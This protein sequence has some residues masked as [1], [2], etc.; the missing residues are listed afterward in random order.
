M[1]HQLLNL[2]RPLFVLDVETTGLDVQTAR[3]VEIGFQEW[4]AEGMIR[5][6]RSLVN[7]GVPIPEAATAVHRITDAMMKSCQVC[8]GTRIEHPVESFPSGQVGT[9][10]EF[11]IVPTFKQLASSL[12]SGFRDCDFAGKNVRI[13]LRLLT[14]EI[15]RAGQI[16]S[17]AGARIVD[18]DRLEQLAVPRDLGA[19]H[20]KYVGRKHDG[21]HGALAD[22]RA[23][24]TV[25]AKQLEAHAALPRDLDALHAAQWPG[26][27]TSAGEF[28]MI[29]GVA[30]IMFGKH[31][32][33]MTD[34]PRDYWDWILGEAFPDDVKALATRALMG[35][36]PTTSWWFLP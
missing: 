22:A 5:E 6:W 1:I 24:A 3:I 9:C 16:W 27:L 29:D 17:Y 36:F 7:P 15:R 4:T 26:W 20:E 19:L 23:A 33:R 28:R 32:G 12:A 11:H 25:I 13:D 2:T 31:R 18:V 35:E 34:V 14:A 21:A 10:L 30:M 8:G